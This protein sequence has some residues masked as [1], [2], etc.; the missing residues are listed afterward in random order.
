[1]VSKKSDPM[2]IWP[3]QASEVFEFWV[4][5]FPVAPLFGVKWRFGGA[6]GSMIPGMK[7]MMRVDSGEKGAAKPPST[8]PAPP[9]KVETGETK[10][11]AA[12]EDAVEV[13]AAAQE[14]AATEAAAPPSD[15]DLTRIKG[16]GLGLAKQLNDLGITNL[17][18]LASL[19]DDHVKAL[20]VGLQGFKGRCSRE[21]WVGQAKALVG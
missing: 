8:P 3:K 10:I 7:F 16:I 17:H 2:G 12:A 13:A 6:M 14:L 15:D 11:D 4:S 1:M 9:P 19:S 18:Q 20:D 5:L 21:D